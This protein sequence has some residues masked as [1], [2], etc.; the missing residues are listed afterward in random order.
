MERAGMGSAVG[1]FLAL[2]RTDADGS[3][4]RDGDFKSDSRFQGERGDDSDEYELSE[5]VDDGN[6]GNG[7]GR[8]FLLQ[9]AGCQRL[10][11]ERR[12]RFSP[13]GE[14]SGGGCGREFGRDV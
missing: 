1:N 11:G 9:V 8:E 12:G 3:D 13:D 7:D 6:F 4:G 2:E 10:F 5:L 14:F